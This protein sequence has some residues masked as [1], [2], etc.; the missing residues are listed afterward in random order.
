MPLWTSQIRTQADTV[1]RSMHVI[2]CTRQC[3]PRVRSLILFSIINSGVVLAG[4]ALIYPMQWNVSPN[5]ITLFYRLPR[6]RVS[7]AVLNIIEWNSEWAMVWKN[8]VLAY[9]SI[10]FLNWLVVG[11][12]KQEILRT[13][14]DKRMV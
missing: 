13:A 14:W 1:F 12:S 9:S 5:W 6:R 10:L 2:P 4:K 7:A 3:V 8:A 11:V